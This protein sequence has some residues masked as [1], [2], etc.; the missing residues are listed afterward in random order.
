MT[1]ISSIVNKRSRSTNYQASSAAVNGGIG[2][3]SNQTAIV[4]LDKFRIATDSRY[5]ESGSTENNK[6]I[7]PA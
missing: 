4:G 2:I 5:H 1:Q 6:N 7:H 3:T